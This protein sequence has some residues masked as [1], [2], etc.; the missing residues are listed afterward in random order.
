[1]KTGRHDL[2]VRSSW[3]AADWNNPFHGGLNGAGPTSARQ[4]KSGLGHTF[5]FSD[6]MFGLGIPPEVAY[7]DVPSSGVHSVHLWMM[8]DGALVDRVVLTTNASYDPNSVNDPG[9]GAGIGPPA[10]PRAPGSGGS[11]GGGGGTTLNPAYDAAGNLKQGPDPR[12]PGSHGSVTSG[13]THSYVYDAWNRLVT[14]TDDAL[15]SGAGLL[16]ARYE[17]DGLSRRIVRTLSNSGDLNATCHDDFDGQ[18]VV[19]T[20]SGGTS[21]GGLVIRH[22][23]W[24]LQYIDEL[25]QVTVNRAFL[26]DPSM[27]ASDPD[28]D[29]QAVYAVLDPMFSLLGLVDAS[30]DLVE[31]YELDP[32]G[33]RQVFGP[34]DANDTTLTLALNSPARVEADTVEQPY[35]L[36]DV[37]HQ[38]LPLDENTGLLYNRARYRNPATGRFISRD[39]LGYPDGMNG[40]AGW[41]V[42]SSLWDPLGLEGNYVD[43][44]VRG[45]RIRKHGL[46]LIVKSSDT[47]ANWNPK[48]WADGYSTYKETEFLRSFYTIAV[49]LQPGKAVNAN[50]LQYFEGSSWV[51]GFSSSDDRELEREVA[52]ALPNTSSQRWKRLGE[53]AIASVDSGTSQ[54]LDGRCVECEIVVASV[55]FDLITDESGNLQGASWL[56]G[57]TVSAIPAIPAGSVAGQLITQGG[58]GLANSLVNHNARTISFLLVSCADGK[59]FSGIYNASNGIGDY[60]GI[61]LV[62][63]INGNT[64][65]QYNVFDVSYDGGAFSSELYTSIGGFEGIFHPGFIEKSQ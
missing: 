55:N 26:D 63:T 1:M 45:N 53:E 14:V 62:R 42:L 10:S 44:H 43:A 61:N 17:Y 22:Q 13:G 50:G 34:A 2:W 12:N 48:D 64:H 38:G 35:A 49:K 16:I 47:G 25:V 19:E 65:R 60:R 57:T 3:T 18:R 30:G 56:A 36:T 9:N 6:T 29:V 46:R 37:S 51:Q 8:D 32:Y 20:R 4:I 7:L 58:S 41:H 27:D 23:V 11:G 40:Y 31:R 15:D 21:G 39:P 52:N 59:K 33:H 5:F 54:P 24:G 28:H